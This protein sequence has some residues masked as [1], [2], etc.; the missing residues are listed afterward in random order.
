MKSPRSIFRLHMSLWI[1][2]I[3]ITL[4]A[5]SL[6]NFWSW[7]TRIAFA[8][9]LGVGVFLLV[10]LLLIIKARSV[11]DIR[12]NAALMDQAG[13]AVVPL[14]ILAGVASV[15][16]IILNAASHGKPSAFDAVVTIVTLALSWLFVQV[17]FALHY[18]H[19]YYSPKEDG[20]GD[21]GGMAFA[22][23]EDPDYLDFFYFST[24]IGMAN[25][26]ADVPLNTKR[27]RRLSNVHSLIAWLFNTVILALAINLAVTLL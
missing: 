27:M 21:R 2:L 25:E 4:V 22:G 9:H 7:P 15:F 23:G 19:E 13:R 20:S 18:A 1:A 8:W 26:S 3:V 24:I 6:P 5:S 14:S 12:T 16:V 17:I 10:T 11:T